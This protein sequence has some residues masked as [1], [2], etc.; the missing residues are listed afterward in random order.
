MENHIRVDIFWTLDFVIELSLYGIQ[1]DLTALIGA[2]SYNRIA[3]EIYFSN[4]KSKTFFS[5]YICKTREI[6]T[7]GLRAAFDNMSRR[8]SASELIPL[9][10][11]PAMPPR[12]R[13]DGK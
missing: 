7:H 13:S 12:R 9:I 3:I 10:S 5:I 6:S 1:R 8:T 2:F 4:G 11:F